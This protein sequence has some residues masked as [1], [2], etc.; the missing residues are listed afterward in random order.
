MRYFNILSS[1]SD[2]IANCC[3]DPG[4]ASILSIV[5]TFISV[6]QI[7]VPILLIVMV[8]VEFTKLTVSPDDK[9][10]MKPLI[11]KFIAA[12]FVFI[13]PIIVDVGLAII[14]DSSTV[15]NKWDIAS[16]WT[17]AKNTSD[18]LRPPE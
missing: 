11:N 17:E 18:K 9:K 2:N 8:A 7:V 14:N 13:I 4:L 15:G 1:C 6:I 16:C 5:Q 3:S 12:V 10:G